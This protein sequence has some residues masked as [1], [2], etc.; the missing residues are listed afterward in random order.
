MTGISVRVGSSGGA[1]SRKCLAKKCERVQKRGPKRQKCSP[2]RSGKAIRNTI[3]NSN[4]FRVHVG[5]FFSRLRKTI[6][7]GPALHRWLG[8]DEKF[9]KDRKPSPRRF[10]GE[11]SFEEGEG[12]YGDLQGFGEARPS[13]LHEP[14][15]PRDHGDHGQPGSPRDCLGSPQ[16]SPA[17]PASQGSGKSCLRP[18]HGSAFHL[19]RPVQQGERGRAGHQLH[20]VD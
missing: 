3:A 5:T 11:T 14:H 9:K 7:E 17:R 2:S 19:L 6:A 10:R 20:E 16:V 8:M 12:D 1:D 15:S 4:G 18:Y 13:D